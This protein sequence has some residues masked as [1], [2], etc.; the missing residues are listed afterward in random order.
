MRQVGL[1]PTHLRLYQL[2]YCHID[3]LQSRS[4]SLFEKSPW[5]NE[6]DSFRSIL[7]DAISLVGNDLKYSIL[8]THVHYIV[9]DVVSFSN[10][11]SLTVFSSLCFLIRKIFLSKFLCKFRIRESTLFFMISFMLKIFFTI[12]DSPICVGDLMLMSIFLSVL[13]SICSIT[14]LTDGSISIRSIISFSKLFKIF[15]GIAPSTYFI[16]KLM[17]AEVGI[18]PTTS[19]L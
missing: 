13:S 19:G 4:L 6:Y 3:L 12:Y 17:V 10:P 7:S 2:S 18:E 9:S 16:H 8:L 5:S 11:F 14:F 15:F 1:E